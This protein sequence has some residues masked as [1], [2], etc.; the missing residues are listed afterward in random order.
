[1]PQTSGADRVIAPEPYNGDAHVGIGH[2]LC[3]RQDLRQPR[4]PLAESACG[5]P[6]G[7]VRSITRPGPVLLLAALG[8]SASCYAATVIL[9]PVTTNRVAVNW[10][11]L[12]PGT[13]YYI[14]TSTNLRTW[15]LAT[16][17]TATNLDLTFVG[18]NESG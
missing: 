18:E 8:A 4:S 6:S 13:R 17:T 9:P 16:N 14:Q 1:M 15:T 7:T 11:A 2:R 10:G 5:R 12:G 3:E